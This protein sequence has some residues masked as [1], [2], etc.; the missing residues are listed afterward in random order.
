MDSEPA[1][2]K[3]SHPGGKRVKGQKQADGSRHGNSRAYIEA[4]LARD[5]SEGCREAAVLLEGV[6]SGQISLYAAAVEMNY[7]RRRELRGRV[8][9]PNVTKKN[10][11]R[12]H[13]LFHPRPTL[14][15]PEK[16]PPMHAE[17]GAREETR[18]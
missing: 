7:T 12:M 17:S 5:A 8:E 9:Y 1:P 11:W 3:L 2:F 18:E 13:R 10:D 16:T 4:R 14:K 6:R 15:T